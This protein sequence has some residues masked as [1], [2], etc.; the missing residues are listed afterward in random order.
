M[1]DIFNKCYEYEECLWNFGRKTRR[2]WKI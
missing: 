1:G 2:T